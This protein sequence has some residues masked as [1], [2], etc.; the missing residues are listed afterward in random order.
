MTRSSI[1][2]LLGAV[3]FGLLAAAG[4]W[5]AMR[6]ATTAPEAQAPRNHVVVAAKAIEFGRRLDATALKT[7]VWPGEVPEN[8]YRKIADVVQDGKRTALRN[9]AAGEPIF[10]TAISGDLGRLASSAQLGPD[11]RA[12][13]IAITEVSGAG[14]FVAPGDRVD[15]LVTQGGRDEP[16]VNEVVAQN[17]RVLAVGQTQDPAS[18]EPQ[19]VKSLTL[20]ASPEDAQRILLARSIG[21]LDVML[22]GTGDDSRLAASGMDSVR[23]FGIRPSRRQAAAASRAEPGA[24]PAA[25]RGPEV[26]VL[27]GTEATSYQVSK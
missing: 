27:R 22:R 17:L 14:G 5:V 24:A 15:V 8:A 25:R 16:A 18:S 7:I 20:E 19:L 12:V 6:P 26:A 23:A 11:M 1:F 13:A 10:A 9:F 21:D 3:L 2:M 4:A